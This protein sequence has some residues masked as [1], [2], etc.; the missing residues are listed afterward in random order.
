MSSCQTEMTCDIGMCVT[1]S[2]STRCILGVELRTDIFTPGFSVA[3]PGL[4]GAPGVANGS[5]EHYTKPCRP[6]HQHAV[7]AV[8]SQA[9]ILGLIR[10]A[11]YTYMTLLPNN[12]DWLLTVNRQAYKSSSPTSPSSAT[13]SSNNYN[14]GFKSAI[15]IA[16]SRSVY[17]YRPTW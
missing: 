11:K 16:D 6:P 5:A 17:Q 9:V 2:P 13:N 15:L 10:S 7:A 14:A 3:N 8:Q 12:K 4:P 1:P